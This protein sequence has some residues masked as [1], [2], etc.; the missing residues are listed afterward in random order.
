MFE[1][2]GNG[3]ELMKSSARVLREHPGLLVFPLLSTIACLFVMGSFALP[4]FLSGAVNLDHVQPQ[5]MTHNPLAYVVLF[6]FYFCNYFVIV[7][8]NSAL[9]ACAVIRFNGG[10]P[11]VSDGFQAAVAR[12]PQILAWSLVSA[13][14]GFVLKLIESRSERIGQIV[15]GLLGLAWGIA[16]FFV[17]PA[18]VIEGTG[19]V[20]AIKRSGAILRRTWGEAFV[21]NQSIGFFVFLFVLLALVPA[22]LGFFVGG[23][24]PI[25]VGIAASVVLIIG[26][27]IVSAALQTI[28]LGALYVY[29]AEGRVPLAFNGDVLRSAFGSRR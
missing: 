13:T 5:Q 27:S 14:V 23:I 6:A 20:E 18:I 8:F 3:W 24:A 11:S 12:L 9:V 19:P 4:L 15:S 7:F 1:K 29:A 22:G 21:A 25:A 26:L 16:T 2:I 10:T 28:L 17:V